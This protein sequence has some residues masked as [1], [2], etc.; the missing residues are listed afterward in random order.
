MRHVSVGVYIHYVLS[1]HSYPEQRA[2]SEFSVPLKYT[3]AAD[4]DVHEHSL[5]VAVLKPVTFQIQSRPR[6]STVMSCNIC[7][8]KAVL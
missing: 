2:I 7:V 4:M 1:S 8:H 5:A 6:K 3:C